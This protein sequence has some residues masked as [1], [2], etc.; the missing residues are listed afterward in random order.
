MYLSVGMATPSISY[1]CLT[2]NPFSFSLLYCVNA[3]QN[4]DLRHR[5]LKSPCL[6]YLNHSPEANM[7]ANM[8][9]GSLFVSVLLVVVKSFPPTLIVIQSPGK[10]LDDGDGGDVET[11]RVLKDEERDEESRSSLSTVDSSPRPRPEGHR[12]CIGC[13]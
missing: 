8:L 11:P 7:R 9:S 3:A 4:I 5:H 2:I 10:D 13:R 6:N 12:R 1:F